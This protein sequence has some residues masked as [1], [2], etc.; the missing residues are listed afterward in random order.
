MNKE[1]SYHKV[2]ITGAEGFVGQH[3]AQY[4]SSQNYEVSGIYFVPPQ[5]SIGELY[6]CDIRN[7][8]E[9][10]NI[11]KKVSPDAI[12]HLAGQ[13]SVSQAEKKLSD[14]LAINTQG[15]LNLLDVVKELRL[16]TRFVYI[17]SS[18][19]YG[20]TANLTD[21]LTEQSNANPVSFYAISKYF[22]E[23]IC[24]Y[25]VEHFNLDVIILRPFSHTGPGQSEIF[26]FP[27]IA[28]KIAEIESG[29]IEP[30]ITVGNLD[31]RRDYS[32]IND[33][34]KAYRLAMERCKTGEIY[35]ITSGKSYSIRFGIEYLLSLSKKKIEVNTNEELVR[36]NDIPLL[37]GS[38]EKFIQET[39]WK[40]QI[41]F[42]TTLGELLTYY[43][44]K[45]NQS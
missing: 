32:D 26:I 5:K 28:K 9:L 6:Q 11:L 24:L 15:T 7:R 20:T 30:I 1:K 31:V 4:L 8:A 37:T 29:I 27:K 44:A 3:L 21:K 43:R 13:S 45:I 40:P 34:T 14:T 10:L 12:F 17:S 35:N 23:K 36:N 42:V 38:A 41:D 19:I 18:D 16:K 39:G 33:I 25:Y 2:F 22:A